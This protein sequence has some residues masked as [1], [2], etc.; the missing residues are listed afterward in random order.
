MFGVA[1]D[2]VGRSQMKTQSN[3]KSMILSD[4]AFICV[5]SASSAGGAPFDFGIPEFAIPV[6]LA[7]AG[8]QKALFPE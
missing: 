7:Q 6:I 4:P 1:A 5:E 3:L 2:G 8:I